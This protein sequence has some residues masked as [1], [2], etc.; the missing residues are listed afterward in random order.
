MSWRDESHTYEYRIKA[1]AKAANDNN[2]SKNEAIFFRYYSLIKTLP[3]KNFFK[4]DFVIS[5]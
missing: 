5:G 3:K 1:V 2:E 4:G